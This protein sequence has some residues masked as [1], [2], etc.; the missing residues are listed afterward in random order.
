MKSLMILFSLLLVGCI[1]D[2]KKS[3]MYN[4]KV[5]FNH[6]FYGQCKGYI[7]NK[8]NEKVYE[9]LASCERTPEYSQYLY[10]K[11]DDMEKLK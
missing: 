2:P 7:T 1:N 10:I 4:D 9:V 11:S 6:H 5:I 8:I 3:F